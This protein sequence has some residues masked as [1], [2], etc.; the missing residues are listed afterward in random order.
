MTAALRLLTLALLFALGTGCDALQPRTPEA[1]AEESGTFFQPDTPEQVIDNLQAAVAELNTLTYR[2][3]LSD[4][5]VFEPTPTAE[6]QNPSLWPTWSR[7]EEERYFNT[8]AAA[9]TF[10]SGHELTFQEAVLAIV[11]ESEYQYD[12]RYTLVV[13]HRRPAVPTLVTG[14]LVWTLTQGPDGLW[15][16]ARWTDRSTGDDPTWS[17]LKVAFVQ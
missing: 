13:Q 10:A 15:S 8:L 11:S 17:D 5:L 6:T 3:S 16:L 9:A 14:R 1:P 7:A 4:A 12:A 2:R